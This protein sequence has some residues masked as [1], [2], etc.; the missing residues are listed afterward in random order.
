MLLFCRTNVAT[1]TSYKIKSPCDIS[2][3]P[4]PPLHAI[5]SV[6]N[7][8]PFNDTLN[9][10]LSTT[11]PVLFGGSENSC[12]PKNN[13]QSEADATLTPSSVHDTP[14]ESHGDTSNKAT[15]QGTIKLVVDYFI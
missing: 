3:T 15:A 13:I 10:P 9:H 4:S 1:P 14:I 6:N 11:S 7:S 12:S 8:T 5:P 2:L